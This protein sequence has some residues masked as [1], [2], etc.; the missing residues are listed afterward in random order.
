MQLRGRNPYPKKAQRHKTN[1]FL[2]LR[3]LKKAKGQ[4][5]LLED[6]QRMVVDTP[7]DPNCKLNQGGGALTPRRPSALGG[8]AMRS[9]S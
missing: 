7:K 4:Y 5:E 9:H 3:P 1:I 2:R 6:T 8:C